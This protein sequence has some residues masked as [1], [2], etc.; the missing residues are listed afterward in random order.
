MDRITI[1]DVAERA[2][3]SIATVS[4][5]I[6][7]K[8]EFLLKQST[9]DKIKATIREL[10]YLPNRSAASLRQGFSKTIGVLMNFRTDTTSG[11]VA[12]IMRGMLRALN[13]IGYDL[14]LISQEQFS[15]F[16]SLLDN[17]GID[18]LIITHAYH[19]AYPNLEQ[20]LKRSRCFPLI[21]INDYREDLNASQVYI[22]TY[23]A[24][25]DM[26]EYVIKK[27]N[28]DIYLLAGE[29]YSR[30][31]QARERAV[32]EVL[33]AYKIDFNRDRIIN[34]H[35]SEIGGYES[36]KRIFLENPGFRGLIYSLNDAMAIGVL[37]ALGELGFHCPGD[38]KV[39]GFDDIA[40]TEHMNPPLTTVHVPLADMGYEAVNIL[41]GIL[42]GDRSDVKK[43]QFD[44][45]LTQR[46]SC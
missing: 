27:G 33:D 19:I 11:Y 25:Y 14:K 21:V 17:A 43:L 7:P 12:E 45:R 30:D 6:N 15:S 22:D 46:E 40:I 38:I 29:I 16:R 1:K 20:E 28:R 35:F 13:G 5:A 36:T 8:T 9:L 34:G 3:V 26:A 39:V 31:A 2:G 42:T 18:G 41:Y 37:R 10:G 23:K 32:L 44:Y 4:R 24:T